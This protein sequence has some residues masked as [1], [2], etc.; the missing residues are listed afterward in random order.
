VKLIDIDSEPNAV[1][2]YTLPSSPPDLSLAPA[3][4]RE[5]TPSPE[6]EILD[7]APPVAQA[8]K[9][10]KRSAPEDG[11]V[12]LGDDAQKKRKVEANSE[13]EPIT[14]D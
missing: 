7:G 9:S 10:N 8:I 5:S 1:S 2:A 11:D 13:D 6:P 12:S 4:P 14:I 3:K